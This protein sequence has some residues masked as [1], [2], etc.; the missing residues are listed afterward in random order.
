MQWKIVEKS[1]HAFI[2]GGGRARW[3][4]LVFDFHEHQVEEARVLAE[5]WGVEEFV[6]KKSS[7]IYYRTHI[8][9]KE[10]SMTKIEKVKKHNY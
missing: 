8:R 5:Q 2:E 7:K 9:E 3:D 10:S 4:F 6:V 1:F